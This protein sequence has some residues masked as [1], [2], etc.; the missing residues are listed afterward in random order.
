MMQQNS[1]GFTIIEVVL[2]L[3]VGGLLGVGILAGASQSVNQQRYQD[4][5]RSLASELQ[6]QYS[7]VVNVEN[8]RAGNSYRCNPSGTV[9]DTSVSGGVAQSR[10]TSD[11]TIVGRVIDV[12]GGNRVV[13]SQPVYATA[14]PMK[15]S[16]LPTSDVDALRKSNLVVPTAATANTLGR[17]SYEMEWGTSS[18]T[19]AGTPR[20]FRL[21]VVRSPF[22]NMVRTYAVVGSTIEPTVTSNIRDMIGREAE[23]T[24]CVNPDGLFTG[25]ELGVRILRGASTA[26]GVK[27]LEGGV[28]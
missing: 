9:I 8:D 4:G 28:C 14:D 3:A 6:S 21:L 11:C 17:D 25:Q 24:I 15:D 19:P 1:S 27:Q 7:A 18:V 23:V 10:G 22:S 20:Q 26:A 13:T 2:F 16:I 5:V 12:T